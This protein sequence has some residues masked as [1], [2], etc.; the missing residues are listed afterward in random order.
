MS[1]VFHAKLLDSTGKVVAEGDM[2]NTRR[3]PEDRDVRLF[4]LDNITS[5]AYEQP[6]PHA[7]APFTVSL[8]LRSDTP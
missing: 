1:T 4:V 2:V 8:A 6:A 7:G 5:W 3:L